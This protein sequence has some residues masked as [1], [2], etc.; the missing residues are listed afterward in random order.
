MYDNLTTAALTEK[1]EQLVAEIESVFD[2]AKA[3][4]RDLTRAETR[5]VDRK[6]TECDRVSALLEARRYADPGRG[7]PLV[8]LPATE[9]RA[10]FPAARGSLQSEMVYRPDKSAEVSFIRDLI[11]AGHNLEARSR[12]D[13]NRREVEFARGWSEREAQEYR[14]MQNLST[15]GSEF[16]PPLYL[17]DLWVEPATG[18]R[19]FA[20]ALPSL[21]LPPTG[22]SVSIPKL[23]SG[24]AVAARS[25]A[26]AV[27]ETDA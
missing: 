24:V 23:A 12:L 9:P 3:D 2:R 18:L 26:A 6:T 11:N 25:D 22:T 10:I 21:P 14:D 19:P 13:V 27:Q 7:A 8:A 15:Q 1:A 16:V 4:K 5:E 20:D 17:A